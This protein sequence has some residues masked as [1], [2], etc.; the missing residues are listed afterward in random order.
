ML[1]KHNYNF[2]FDNAIVCGLQQ[3][4]I[5]LPMCRDV[6]ANLVKHGITFIIQIIPEQ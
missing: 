6:N 3:G 4:L 2:F 5:Q 1:S